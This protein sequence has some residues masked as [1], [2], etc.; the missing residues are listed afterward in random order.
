MATRSKQSPGYG[1]PKG[2]TATTGFLN[3]F[4]HTLASEIVA[5][6][7]RPKRSNTIREIS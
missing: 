2:A 6:A 3:P 7:T 4:T 1:Q 5:A